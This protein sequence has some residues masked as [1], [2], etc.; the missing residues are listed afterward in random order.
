M[1]KPQRRRT[2]VSL[3]KP[4]SPATPPS[5]VADPSPT[6]RAY[7]SEGPP[8]L[9]PPENELCGSIPNRGRLIRGLE[10]NQSVL[11]IIENWNWDDQESFCF[12][13]TYN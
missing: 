4:H 9:G 13:P 3:S 1:Q 8:D 10:V 7:S 11:P 5:A 12:T 2:P 6:R